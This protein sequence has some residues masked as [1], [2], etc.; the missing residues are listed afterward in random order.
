MVI[1]RPPQAIAH[2]NFHL[3]HLI[4]RL[5]PNLNWIHLQRCPRLVIVKGS[6]KSNLEITL[7]WE[8]SD[9]VES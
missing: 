6:G 7:E 8:R 9:K 3:L 1:A 5:P 2:R 4:N